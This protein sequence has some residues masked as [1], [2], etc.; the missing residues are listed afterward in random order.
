MLLFLKNKNKKIGRT[1]LVNLSPWLLLLCGMK[2]V[3]L[4]LYPLCIFCTMARTVQLRLFHGGR[5]LVPAAGSTELPDSLPWATGAGTAL[6][7]FPLGVQGEGMQPKTEILG[8]PTTGWK[9][10]AV[11]VGVG[12]ERSSWLEMLSAFFPE[13]LS[14]CAIPHP[15]LEPVFC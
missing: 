1:R 9:H 6:S 10:K 15:L 12:G 2:G 13:E 5:H 11:Q 4:P 3:W 7:Y 8:V 14:F